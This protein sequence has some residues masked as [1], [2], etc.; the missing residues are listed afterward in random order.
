MSRPLRFGSIVHLEDGHG[1]EITCI[2][3]DES[4]LYTSAG[5]DQNA[6]VIVRE[7]D[8]LDTIAVLRHPQSVTR[9]DVDDDFVYTMCNG[10]VHGWSK[11]DWRHSF[12]LPPREKK[13]SE[14]PTIRYIRSF[15]V[16]ENSIYL[17]YDD[18]I[19][20]IYDKTRRSLVSEI[21]VNED[22]WAFGG[23]ESLRFSKSNS[24]LLFAIGDRGKINI[25]KKGSW[26][27]VRSFDFEF[28]E[29]IWLSDGADKL[30]ICH[31]RSKVEVYSMSDWT[32]IK[33][34]DAEEYQDFLPW[35]LMSIDCISLLLRL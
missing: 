23:I 24:S 20:E 10:M 1:E 22:E 2:T 31:G 17:G 18:C 35:Q 29:T 3:T 15:T 27:L 6:V 25:L 14:F 21:K 9:I 12:I 34:M 33:T 19:V 26:K 5:R 16:D 28:G 30:Y 32:H 8:S 4:Y 7:V 13:E 11:R